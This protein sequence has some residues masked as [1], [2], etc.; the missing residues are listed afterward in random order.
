[1]QAGDAYIRYMEMLDR[2]AME[3]ATTPQPT[4]PSSSANARSRVGRS[5]YGVEK[6]SQATNVVADFMDKQ[7]M[8]YPET[9]YDVRY[10]HHYVDLPGNPDRAIAAYETDVMGHMMHKRAVGDGM[11]PNLQVR[12]NMPARMAVPSSMRSSTTPIKDTEM[13][14]DFPYYA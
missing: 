5:R 9:G 1:M 13:Y 8:A 14:G 3:M 7:A 11:H 2:R 10:R 6:E 12:G 4:K